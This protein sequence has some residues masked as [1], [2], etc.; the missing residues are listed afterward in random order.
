M[1]IPVSV[2]TAIEV[3]LFVLSLAVLCIGLVLLL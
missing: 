2:A 1:K 3:V